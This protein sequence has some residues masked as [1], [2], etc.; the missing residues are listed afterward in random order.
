MSKDLDLDDL[1]AMSVTAQTELAELGTNIIQ[2]EDECSSLRNQYMSDGE[3]LAALRAR[4]A[5]LEGVLA[6]YA[7]EMQYFPRQIVLECQQK[8]V[9]L[10]P[11][12]SEFGNLARAA[13]KGGE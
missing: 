6:W 8:G 2:L 5:E 3:E 12:Y 10:A 9:R 1:A 4:V 11:I 13:L 7:D